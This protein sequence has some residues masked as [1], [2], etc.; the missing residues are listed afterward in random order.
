[1]LSDVGK[2]GCVTNAMLEAG[3]VTDAKVAANAAIANTKLAAPK[4]FFTIAVAFKDLAAEDDDLRE[5]QM[6]FAATLVEV[7][8]SCQSATGTTA[9]VDVLE[10]GASIL[11]AAIDVK[12]A[13]GTPQVAAPAN[14]AVADNAVVGVKLSQTGAGA[15]AGGFAVLTFKV[16]H[17]S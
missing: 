17:T 7:S 13:A 2:P 9:T 12:T 10:A 3:A 5:F 11:T 6:P 15:T 8:A 14:A 16:A 4:S 1:V